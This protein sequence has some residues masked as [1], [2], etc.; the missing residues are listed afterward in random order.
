MS[1]E[2]FNARAA[3]WDEKI[4]E[5]DTSK[6]EAMLSRIDI[7]PGDAV[8]DVGT[9]T[10][11]F[12]PYLLRKIGSR[13][14]FVCLDFAED[15]LAIA[16]RKDFPGNISYFCAD[17]EDSGLPGESFDAVVCYSVFPHFQDKHIGLSDDKCNFS[18]GNLIMC[19]VYNG[20]T[21]TTH[22]SAFGY[23]LYLCRL[24]DRPFGI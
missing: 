22:P 16:R 6:L 19:R 15:M 9:G 13:G 23:R 17:I 2:F 12:V 8:L 4:A 7:K 18:T 10:G 14:S 21:R 5:K 24:A 20:Q 1:R 3:T 11:V